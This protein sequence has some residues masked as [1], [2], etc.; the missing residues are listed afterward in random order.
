MFPTTDQ[1][2]GWYL[3]P[4]SG[5]GIEAHVDPHGVLGPP[6]LSHQEEPGPQRHVAP[7]AAGRVDRTSRSTRTLSPIVEDPELVA[8]ARA[9][10]DWKCKY[11]SADNRAGTMDCH[12]CGAGPDGAVRRAETLVPVTPA[13]PPA[14]KGPSAKV[15]L[16]ILG[17][18]FAF[19]GVTVWLLFV[20]T[21][22]LQVVV[23]SAAWVKT[24]QVEERRTKAEGAWQDKVPAGAR[25]VGKETRKRPK[26]VQDGTKRIK[27]GQKDLGNG[28]FE[29]VYEEK[30]N[31]VTKDVDDTWVRYEVDTWVKK[32]KLEK[33]SADGT[34]PPIRPEASPRAPDSASATPRTT[35]CSR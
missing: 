10:A 22:S 25:V 17:G 8:R 26:Q 16:A 35:P 32:D 18:V 28:M 11:C 14:K 29:D 9:G 12:Q 24:A 13:G 20:R 30:P 4:N 5:K 7:P 33:K 34:E 6:V 15:V 19:I 21:T 27:V 2:V 31:M 3:R 1:V 23:E